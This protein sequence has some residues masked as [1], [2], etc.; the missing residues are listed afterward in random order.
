M[1]LAMSSM[2]PQP[3]DPLHSAAL[4]ARVA[5]L[6][7]ILILVLM[8]GFRKS[9]LFSSACGLGAAG[10]P[11]GML[12]AAM[13]M[14]SYLKP[15]QKGQLSIPIPSLHNGVLITLYQKPYAAVY[16]FQ[17]LGAGTGVMVAAVLTAL[18]FGAPVPVFFRA[19]LK[20]LRQLRLPGLTVM[21]I[22]G[23]AYLYNYSGMAYTLGAAAAQVGPAFPLLSS[24]LGWVACFLSGSVTASNLLFGNLQAAAAHQLHLSPVLLAG[25]NASGAV[26]GKMVSPQNIAV[27][28]TTVGLISEEGRML[29]STLWHSILF[30]ALIG[31][32][33]FAQA[34][35]LPQMIP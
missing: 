10:L 12:S 17:P 8:G 15:F 2:W 31:L 16:A 3:L 33:T 25:A 23:L 28:V 21:V 14:W 11:W 18:C 7:L 30:A 4:S 20:T 5:A 19:G 35:S 26:A 22:V 32:V 34:Y 9:G 27:G 1:N 6:P 24:Y 13:I 29:R